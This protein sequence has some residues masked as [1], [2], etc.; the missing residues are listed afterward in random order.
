LDLLLLLRSPRANVESLV[1]SARDRLNLG[2]Q[3]LLDP[4][5]VEPILVRDKVNGK[6][7]MSEPA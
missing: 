4:I 5:K 2:A 7:Q 1:N 3:L 6:T